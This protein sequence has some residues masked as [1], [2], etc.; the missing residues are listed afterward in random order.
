[1]AICCSKCGVESPLEGAFHRLQITRRISR[2]YCPLCMHERNT[3][4]SLAFLTAGALALPVGLVLH[5][6]DGHAKQYGWLSL[7]FALF[8]PFQVVC[9]AAHE[10]GH[11]LT[12]KL[13]GLRLFSVCFGGCGRIAFMIRTLGCDVTFMTVPIGGMTVARPKSTRFVRL[14]MLFFVLGGLLANLLF[15]LLSAW[16]W[17]RY[18]EYW[19]GSWV[20]A[21]FG[22][23]NFFTLVVNSVPQVVAING[24]KLPSDGL[25]LLTIPFTSKEHIETM[26]ACYFT[27]EGAEARE[28]GN[29]E[30]AKSWFAQGLAAYPDDVNNWNGLAL[31]LLD[32]GDYLAAKRIYE[33]LLDQKQDDPTCRALFQNNIAWAD[34]MTGDQALLDEADRFSAEA[35][36]VLPWVSEVKGTRGSVLIDLGRIEEGVALVEQAMKHNRQKQNQAFNACYLALAALRLG[37]LEKAAEY[38]ETAIRLDPKCVLLNR[39]DREREKLGGA[40]RA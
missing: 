10:L 18:A 1:M 3:T 2:W 5:Y 37:N 14:R 39:V 34:L 8:V 12:A 17:R 32:D 38:Q 4:S 31:M 40:G 22:A 33:R 21:V 25:Q 23:S 26:H 24:Q 19:I 28:R 13:L 6:V 30:A 16:L 15:V 9:L 29:P 36:Q 20:L 27:L 11:A 7:S 35:F